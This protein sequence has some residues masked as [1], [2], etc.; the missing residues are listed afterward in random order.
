[1][2]KNIF[3]KERWNYDYDC[4]AYNREVWMG[5]VRHEC[6]KALL[7]SN[8]FDVYMPVENDSERGIYVRWNAISPAGAE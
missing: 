7:R 8:G 1:M 2:V 6:N 3:D 5:R 4:G